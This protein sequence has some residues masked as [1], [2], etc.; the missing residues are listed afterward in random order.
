MRVA[1]LALFAQI[2][3]AV[4]FCTN[5]YLPSGSCPANAAD[6]CAANSGPYCIKAG[7]Q[8]PVA[9]VNGCEKFQAGALTGACHQIGNED[10]E[11]TQFPY[12]NPQN[13]N[14]CECVEC[15]SSANCSSIGGL[16]SV[17]AGNATGSGDVYASGFAAGKNS[18]SCV[19]NCAQALRLA[20]A[21][22]EDC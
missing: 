3:S 19:E 20:Y 2:V 13:R 21:E 16:P 11:P 10:T 15:I 5:G 9:N 6:I 14:Y 18:V 22:L 12:C 8:Y 17:C 7:L 4:K 1:I